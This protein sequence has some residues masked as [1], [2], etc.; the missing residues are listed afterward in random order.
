MGNFTFLLLLDLCDIL[1]NSQDSFL[2]LAGLI[3]EMMKFYLTFGQQSPFKNGWVEIE[4]GSSER[5]RNLAFYVFGK[6]WAMLYKEEEFKREY[7]PLGKL[8]ETLK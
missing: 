1:V 5:A 6:H 7:F 2:R 8:G 3:G 4:A